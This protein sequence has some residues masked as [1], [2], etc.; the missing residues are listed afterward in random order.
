MI[1]RFVGGLFGGGQAPEVPS[2]PQVDTVAT[3]IAAM[4]AAVDQLRSAV[5][6]SGSQLPPLLTSQLRQL[7]D[8]MREAVTD[9]GIRGAS[10][11]Q[12]V[13][14]NAMICSYVPTPLQ[15]YLSL[16]QAQHDE[17]SR[18]TFMLAE[19]LATLEETLRDLL[20]QIRIGAVEELSTHGRFLADKFAGQD[21]ALQLEQPP[22]ER[23]PLRLEG[24]TWQH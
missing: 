15:A 16:P 24:Q 23:D 7:G 19:Q 2:A 13:L 14:L 20:N 5:R 18:A 10:T 22:S 11:E 12:R 9:I 4:G 21:A 3:E 1:G 6:R 8:L 17:E